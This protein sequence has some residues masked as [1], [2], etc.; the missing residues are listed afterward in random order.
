MPRPITPQHIS[1]ILDRLEDDSKLG[2]LFQSLAT[3]RASL[4]EMGEELALKHRTTR[5]EV[6]QSLRATLRTLQATRQ[7]DAARQS[8]EERTRGRRNYQ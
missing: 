7:Q 1:H 6:E 4:Q 2:P 5:S 8:R 3:L